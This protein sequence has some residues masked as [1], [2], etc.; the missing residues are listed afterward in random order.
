M[1]GNVLFTHID[2]LRDIVRGSFTEDSVR[3]YLVLLSISQT[4]K[5]NGLDFFDFIRSGEKDI[6]AFAA[7]RKLRK[8]EKKDNITNTREMPPT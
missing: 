2:Q 4:C 6:Y 1:I 3:G 8:S 5:C 7:A